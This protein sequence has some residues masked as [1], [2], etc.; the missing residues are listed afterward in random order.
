[1]IHFFFFS[2]ILANFNIIFNHHNPPFCITIQPKWMCERN[3]NMYKQCQLIIEL[4]FSTHN[5]CSPPSSPL[6]FALLY[7]ST[8]SI[9]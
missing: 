9:P 8:L 1:M 4:A 6:L 3:K 2:L 7:L 5:H